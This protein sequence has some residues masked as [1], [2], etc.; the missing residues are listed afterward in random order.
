MKI[1]RSVA[2][3]VGLTATNTAAQRGVAPRLSRFTFDTARNRVS[4]PVNTVK[5]ADLVRALAVKPRGEF[6][7]TEEFRE[8]VKQ[9]IPLGHFALRIPVSTTATLCTATA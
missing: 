6:E 7:T 5:A 9:A 4:L 2:L 1:H 8:R 3:L